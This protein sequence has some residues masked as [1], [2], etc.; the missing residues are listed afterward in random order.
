[1][2]VQ[3]DLQTVEMVRQV[4]MHCLQTIRQI[5]VEKVLR[6]QSMCLQT[7]VSGEAAAA[8]QV[9]LLEMLVVICLALINKQFKQMSTAEDQQIQVVVVMPVPQILAVC[10]FIV[11]EIV[12][13][14]VDKEVAVE[15]D[16]KEDRPA[17]ITMTE[18]VFIERILMSLA[19]L[20][21][22]VAMVVLE[23]DTI[24]D[25][26]LEILEILEIP[27]TVRQI[28]TVR[29]EILETAVHLE[30]PG[31]NQV[32]IHPMQ[33]VVR[34]EEQFSESMETLIMSLVPMQIISKVLTSLFTS[35]NK[36]II[37]N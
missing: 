16:K 4:E 1:L 9:V 18:I 30:E 19:A 24:M 25:K 10:I 37:I 13:E 6:L 5:E 21:E 29:Q 14:Q 23:K 28:P 34:Q 8:E 20:L 32:E 35:L 26:D 33:M 7:V 36:T 3:E 15:E 11:M 17:P 27:Q 31:V 2:V 12:L 22:M